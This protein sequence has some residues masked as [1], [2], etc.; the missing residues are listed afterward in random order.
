MSNKTELIFKGLSEIVGS[1]EL[2]LL[3]LTDTNQT[4][5]VT[6]VCDKL[7]FMQI[8]M[9]KNLP[10]LSRTF[11]PE[12]LCRLLSIN[13]EMDCEIIIN[14]VVEGQYK[15]FVFDRNHLDMIPIRMSD[16]VLLSMISDIRLFIDN[17]LFARQSV[18]FNPNSN[19]VSIP[20]NTLS[21]KMLEEALAKAVEAEDYEMASRLRDEIRS[22][23]DNDSGTSVQ[24]LK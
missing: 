16:A 24:K 13:D 7:T 21:L 23:K 1:S 11:L 2:Y 5:Q 15:A 14:N 22:R 12:V 4:R 3:V 8:D 20:I 10:K 6:I 9:R 18:P 19:G 17:Q